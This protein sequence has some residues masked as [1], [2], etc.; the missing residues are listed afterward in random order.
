VLYHR[1]HGVDDL[2]KPKKER[3]PRKRKAVAADL[4]SPACRIQEF[5]DEE[6]LCEEVEDIFEEED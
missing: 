4:E 1:E 5:S 2:I 3:A 6:P